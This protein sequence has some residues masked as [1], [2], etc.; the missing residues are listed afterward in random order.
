MSIPDFGCE[1]ERLEK[2]MGGKSETMYEMAC[3]LYPIAK[4]KYNV[5]SLKQCYDMIVEKFGR[6]DGSWKD[7]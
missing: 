1:E 7:E 3:K 2:E 5:K 6:D 4:R